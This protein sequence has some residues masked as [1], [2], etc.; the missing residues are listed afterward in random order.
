MQQCLK[1]LFIGVAFFSLA[2]CDQNTPT[3]AKRSSG[4]KPVTKNEAWMSPLNLARYHADH[5]DETTRIEL[6]AD[7]AKAQMLSSDFEMAVELALLLPAKQ[8]DMVLRGVIREALAENAVL[9][10]TWLLMV[11]RWIESPRLRAYATLQLAAS[12]VKSGN[13]K[14][15][16]ELI[17]EVQ[18]LIKDQP[19][20][21]VLTEMALVELSLEQKRQALATGELALR[22]IRA[23]DND[24]FNNNSFQKLGRLYVRAGEVHKVKQLL[25]SENDL[26]DKSV[27]GGLRVDLAVMIAEEGELAEALKWIDTFSERDTPDKQR[28]QKAFGGIALKLAENGKLREAMQIIGKAKGLLSLPWSMSDVERDIAIATAES[29]NIEGALKLAQQR[30]IAS[31][32][33]FLAIAAAQWEA[34]LKTEARQSL[35]KA[36]QFDGTTFFRGKHQT[37]QTLALAYLNTE[38]NELAITTLKAAMESAYE[39]ESNRYSNKSKELVIAERLLNMLPAFVMTGDQKEIQALTQRASTMVQA[40]EMVASKLVEAGLYTQAMEIVDTLN[41]PVKKRS[42][43]LTIT[44]GFSREHKSDQY[45]NSS[46]VTASALKNKFTADEQDFAKALIT[47]LEKH[48]GLATR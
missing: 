28:K 46:S 44:K 45:G 27:V 32:N 40:P 23:E 10:P 24:L 31:R 4:L 18:L 3:P 43:L 30:Q 17:T 22:L 29:G 2:G 11:A 39:Y 21:G 37:L 41:E 47:A 48:R 36:A 6:L 5:F 38:Q 14:D 20:I 26:W 16:L 12:L 34:G 19:D 7:T 8:Q 33:V 1:S 25:G 35:N 15:A 42:V 13:R 9:E